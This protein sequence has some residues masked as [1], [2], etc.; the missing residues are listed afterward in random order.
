[1]AYS[2]SV[3]RFTSTKLFLK[4]V[5]LYGAII[6]SYTETYCVLALY[7]MAKK[8]SSDFRFGR[9]GL[10]ALQQKLVFIP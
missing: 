7:K 10:K 5:S 4:I 3:L 2:K 6:S 1:M 8:P 9:Y